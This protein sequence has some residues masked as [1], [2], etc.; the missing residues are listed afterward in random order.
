MSTSKK[1]IALQEL[2][3]AQ[4]EER[5]AKVRYELIDD[6][7][8]WE[9]FRKEF[10]KAAGNPDAMEETI[11][12]FHAI[13]PY[14]DAEEWCNFLVGLITGIPLSRLDSLAQVPSEERQLTRD[15]FT[16][17]DLAT[18]LGIPIS[19]NK[20]AKRYLLNINKKHGDKLFLQ[21]SK[22][23]WRIDL[24]ILSMVEDSDIRREYIVKM[25]TKNTIN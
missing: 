21:A 18:K 7:K 19:D 2:A 9:Y 17:P 15:T 1:Q 20:Q 13:Q 12:R 10:K 8:T 23:K 5:K 25:L 4:E 6:P 14:V 24:S 11:K 3:K 22:Y 16:M